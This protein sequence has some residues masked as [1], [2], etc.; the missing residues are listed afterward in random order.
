MPRKSILMEESPAVAQED[1]VTLQK[2]ELNA[3]LSRLSKLE[4]TPAVS[5]DHKL[6]SGPRK[7][8][9][10]HIDG[11]II[12]DVPS[13]PRTKNEVRKNQYGG[14]EER[15]EI[16][17]EYIDGSKEA[18]QFFDY[19]QA[20]QWTEH[21]FPTNIDKKV[22]VYFAD[23][24]RDPEVLSSADFD[25]YY[26][27]KKQDDEKVIDWYDPKS[28]TGAILKI[29]EWALYTFQSPKLNCGEPFTV[30]NNAIN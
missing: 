21:M 22:K 11:K 20:V 7:Y 4:K 1:T 8:Q 5:T 18:M 6:Y 2:T 13:M 14:W 17:V 12:H 27:V 28:G 23:E 10:R 30:T 3:I 29:E 9:A 19:A 25:E 26:K 24:Y 15:Q 16:E